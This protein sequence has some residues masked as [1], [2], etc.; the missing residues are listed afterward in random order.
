MP[1]G[2]HECFDVARSL[3]ATRTRHKSA[4]HVRWHD[5]ASGHRLPGRTPQPGRVTVVANPGRKRV[6][7]LTRRPLPQIVLQARKHDGSQVVPLGLHV[8]ERAASEQPVDWYGMRFCPTNVQ[9]LCVSRRFPLRLCLFG[10]NGDAADT[11]SS[12]LAFSLRAF[13]CGLCAFA[14]DAFGLV[15]ALPRWGNPPPSEPFEAGPSP[16][17]RTRFAS[18]VPP[19]RMIRYESEMSFAVENCRPAGIGCRPS[20][21]SRFESF[22]IPVSS[23]PASLSPRT[24]IGGGMRSITM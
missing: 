23:S 19:A 8:P 6:T 20:S 1:F 4:V 5:S 11:R 9:N 12:P 3:R 7:F 16:Y 22:A 24:A 17:D 13:L 10:W 2:S 18:N 15:A 21:F 14:L